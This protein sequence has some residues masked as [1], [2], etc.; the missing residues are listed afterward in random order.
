MAE[1]EIPSITGDGEFQRLAEGATS[2]KI[3][4][5]EQSTIKELEEVMRLDHD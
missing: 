4:P 2:W 1:E 5:K 3:W